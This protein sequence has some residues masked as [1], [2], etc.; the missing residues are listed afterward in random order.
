MQPLL[1]HMPPDASGPPVGADEVLQDRIADA[2]VVERYWSKVRPVDGDDCWYWMGA[3]SAKGHG[4]FWL[5]AGHVVIAHRFG[6]ALAHPG[7][8][9]PP[10][11]AHGCDNPLCQ[12]PHLGHMHA[13]TPGE[14]RREWAERRWRIGGPLRDGR[15][16]R[17]RA[18]A[19]REAVRAGSSMAEATA[20]GVS[21]L[22]QGTLW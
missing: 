5:T 3:I 7:E 18:Q 2:A 17:G 21:V 13:S 16:A 11:V 12:S 20:E 8:P 19:L 15:G 22:D 4:R 10:V 9:L 6:Y 14:N 1:P